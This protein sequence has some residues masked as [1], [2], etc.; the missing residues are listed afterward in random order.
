LTE[1]SSGDADDVSG[2]GLGLGLDGFSPNKISSHESGAIQRN[3]CILES[4]PTTKSFN[5][6]LTDRD[7]L[8]RLLEKRSSIT[9]LAETLQSLKRQTPT[10]TRK[11]QN[12]NKKKKRRRPKRRHVKAELCV[13]Q[14]MFA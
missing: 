5:G 6:S 12:T 14:K 11:S 3:T 10:I 1:D 9:R 8:P 4:S 13:L 7:R 2:L